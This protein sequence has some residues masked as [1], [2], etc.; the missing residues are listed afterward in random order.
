MYVDTVKNRSSKPAIL[1]R[2]SYREGQK[3]KKRTLAN[4]S[5]LDE[6][7]IDLIRRSLKGEEFVSTANLTEIVDTEK[8]VPFGHV[9]AVM[10]AM[11][12]LDI[13][14]LTDSAPS[15]ERDLIMG[16]VAARILAAQS[17]LATT[18]WWRN[19]SPGSELNIS[20]ATETEVY[21]AMDWILKKQPDIEKKLAGRHLK[22]GSFAFVDMSSSYYEG[23]KSTLVSHQGTSDKEDTEDEESLVK[24]GYSRDKKRGK[25][26]INYGLVTDKDGRPISITVFPGNTSDAKI[27]FPILSKINKE[28]NLS[29]VVMVG[30]RG[31]I[32]SKG[33]EVLRAREGVDW[34]SA[35]RSTSIKKLIA[36]RKHSTLLWDE[37]N[38][39]EFKDEVQFPGERLVACRNEELKIHREKKREALLEATINDLDKI[40]IRITAGRLKLQDKI[41]MSAG[42]A[43]ARHKMAKHFIVEIKDGFLSYSLNEESINTEKILDGV[44]VIRT[45]VNAD[46]LSSENC[47]RIYK[48]LAQVERAF[49]TM[50]TVNLNIRPIYHHLDERIRAHIFL[51]MLSYYV[52]W[53]MREAW[54]EITFA[55]TETE[56]KETRNPVEKAKRSNKAQQ[57]ICTKLTEDL[58]PVQ[59]FKMVLNTLASISEVT[60][61]LKLKGQKKRNQLLTFKGLPKFEPL[62][63]RAFDLLEKL[64]L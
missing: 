33:I 53:H 10:T 40:K 31:M 35:L 9:Q 60:Y 49:R 12:R 21:A 58:L 57:K 32:T 20:D 41:A 56:L 1:I 34:I 8:T 43:L 17:K 30:D 15:R 61:S 37:R 6:N 13:A 7:T 28:F 2:E 27:F 47:V 18:G 5:S 62:Q 63:K 36:L 44:Y 39:C 16:L 38:L 14:R 22:N 26:Q 29:R 25:P 45:S 24:Y 48:N 3:V 52:E 64:R 19:C 59:K 11:K 4:I 50:K 55:D 54:R 51:T 42:R 46:I 23:G